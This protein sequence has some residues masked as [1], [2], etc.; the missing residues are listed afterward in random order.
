MDVLRVSQIQEWDRYTIEHEPIQSIDLMERASRVFFNWLLEYLD[1]D[2][3]EVLV[4]VSKGNNGGDGLAVA[5]MLIDHG[6]NVAVLILN[7]QPKAS[8]DFQTNLGRL[9]RKTLT[10]RELRAE[11]PIPDLSDYSVIVDGIFGSGLTRTLGG[12]WATVVKHLNQAE[13]TRFSIDIPSGL[14]ADEETPEDAVVFQSD[15]CLS[16]QVAKLSFFFPSNER[17]LNDWEVRSIGLH[18][19]FPDRDNPEFRAN[20]RLEIMPMLKPR[21]RFDHKGDY[22]RVLIAA[23]QRGMAGASILSTRSAIRS[24]AGLVHAL[25]PDCNYTAVQ[26]AVPE[27]MVL[28]GYGHDFLTQVPDLSDFDAIG[29]GPGIGQAEAT[30]DF[31]EELLQGTSKPLVLDADALN[32]IARYRKLLDLIPENSLLTPHP[33]EFRRLFGPVGNHPDRLELLRNK[34]IGHQVIIVLKGAYSIIATPD[35]RLTFNTSGNPGMA[36]G[37]S[38]DVLTGLLTGLLAQ[39]YPPE[40][41]AQIGVFLHGLAGDLAADVLGQQALI[42]SDIVDYIPEAYEFL[43]AYNER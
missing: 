35:G 25:I 41:A 31:L 16:F 14:F 30:R 17:F 12:Y 6:F 28:H 10:I 40:T 11:D 43:T 19:D 2:T 8:P 37:G 39:G 33:G 9:R 26:S 21:K 1:E 24:G 36:S 23:G 15:Y 5:R 32:L 18:P 3:E 22:G 27:A 42:A 4:V 34:A 7:I 29:V 20:T 38:G 13:A